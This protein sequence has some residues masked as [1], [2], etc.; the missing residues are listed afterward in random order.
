M[1]TA[2]RS[3][4][5]N[6]LRAQAFV[7]LLAAMLFGCAGRCVCRR[8]RGGDFGGVINRT[9]REDRFLHDNLPGYSAY[10]ERVRYR[11]VPG[12]W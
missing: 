12:L 9:A 2:P 3:I 1:Q 10:A 8:L 4:S 11:L 6:L 5:V 7:V